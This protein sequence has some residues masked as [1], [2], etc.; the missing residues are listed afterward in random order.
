LRIDGS[1]SP[2]YL[3]AASLARPSRSI[4][5]RLAHAADLPVTRRASL[6]IAV[7]L[8][9]GVYARARLAQVLPAPLLQRLFAVFIVGMA[10]RLWL[11]AGSA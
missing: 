2:P 1:P 3:S 11:K 5:E 10:I 6:L 7:G 4:K 9:L 8:S